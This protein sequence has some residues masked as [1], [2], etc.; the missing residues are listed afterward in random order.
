MA[1]LS[2]QLALGTLFLPSKARI[3]GVLLCPPG[4]F[5]NAGHLNSSHLVCG[6]DTLTAE[7]P[8]Q[9]FLSLEYIGFAVVKFFT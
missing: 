8:P 6:T 3:T 5:M 7:P 2:G 9:P 1:S 4:T